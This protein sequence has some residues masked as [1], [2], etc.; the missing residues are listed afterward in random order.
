MKLLLTA[1]LG[2]LVKWLRI[3]GL[4]TAYFRGQNTSS[5]IIESLRQERIIVTRNRH[6]PKP[7]GARIVV[8][9]ADK[10][11]EEL[12][13]T[14]KILQIKPVSGMMFTRCI[15]CNEP[16]VAAEKEKVKDRVPAYVFA[17]QEKFVTCPACSRIYWQGTHW[18]NVEKLLKEIDGIYS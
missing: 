18:G 14:L 8:I 7:T 17:T 16:L 10:L 15:L 2:R 3:L 13:A 5:L 11:K 12:A 9:K 6:L 4:D 1:E